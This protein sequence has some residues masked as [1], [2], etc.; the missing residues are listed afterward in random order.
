MRAM[1]AHWNREIPAFA[2]MGRGG[3]MG[4]RGGMG[5]IGLGGVFFGGGVFFWDVSFWGVLAE[6]WRSENESAGA[7]TKQ[8]PIPAKAGI[9]RLTGA[10]RATPG[11]HRFRGMRCEQ[12]PAHW[13]RE[14]P[15]FAGMGRGGGWGKGGE[16][17]VLVWGVFLFGVF[18]GKCWWSENEKAK[19]KQLPIPAK[20]G[21]GE[22][23]GM[24]S[25]NFCRPPFHSPPLSI[26]AKAGIS[27][28]SGAGQATPAMHRLL[29]AGENHFQRFSQLRSHMRSRS[30]VVV[31]DDNFQRRPLGG[32]SV[33]AVQINVRA[34]AGVCRL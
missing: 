19:T 33:G 11:L 34:V 9:S 32:V 12:L 13:N 28:S 23:A 5:G 7:K 1:P 30:S 26:P 14:I 8:L 31:G 24:G 18:F 20:A 15:A 21:M 16:W 25:M 22:G 17:E 4:E 10:G 27:L 2:G 29:P 6:C 3:G